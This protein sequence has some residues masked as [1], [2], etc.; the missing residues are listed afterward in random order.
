MALQLALEQQTRRC[1]RLN[2]DLNSER[3]KSA[4]LGAELAEVT[5]RVAA[6]ERRSVAAED[7]G[8]CGESVEKVWRVWRVR[9]SG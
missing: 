5:S 3:I 4:S 1:G 8:E 9:M 6:A 7:L 2:E